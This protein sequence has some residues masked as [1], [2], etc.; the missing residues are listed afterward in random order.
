[1][2]TDARPVPEFLSTE[3]YSYRGSE[4]LAASRYTSAEFKKLED[5]K[6][7]PNVWQFAARR[8]VN[9]LGMRNFLMEFDDAET[10][11]GSTRIY[12]SARDWAR[13]GNLHLNDGVV[14]GKRILPKGWVTYSTQQNTP[15]FKCRFPNRAQSRAD[16]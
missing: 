9:R 16:A 14:N 5:E 15:S 1:M 11:I 2:K 13:F 4:P 10:P 12:A 7:W 6:L 3:S 8:L